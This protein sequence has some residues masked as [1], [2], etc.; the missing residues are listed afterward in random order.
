MNNILED[1]FLSKELYQTVLNPVCCQYDMTHTEMIVLLFLANNPKLN[2]ATDIVKGR[3]LT[4]SSISMAVKTLQDRGLIFGEFTDGNH[5]SIHLH[6]SDSAKQIV[7]DGQI[8]QNKFISVLTE[9]FSENETAN[10]KHYFDR[11]SANIKSY[12]NKNT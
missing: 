12:Y 1:I 10:F 2:T 5:R 4:K 7:R 3:G 8:A 9:G 6:I 11:V